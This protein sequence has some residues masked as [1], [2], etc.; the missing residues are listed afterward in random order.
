METLL[1]QTQSKQTSKLLVEL[2]KKMGDKAQVLNPEIAED[3]TLGLMMTQEK[4][5]KKVSKASILEHLS[6]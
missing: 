6:K 3:L 5:G 4:T 1:I 2:V